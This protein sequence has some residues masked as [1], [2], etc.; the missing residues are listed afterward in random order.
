[1]R[2]DAL[3]E[4]TAMHGVR[5]SRTSEESKRLNYP[6]TPCIIISASGMATG[7]R[8]VH[9][10]A[11]LLPHEKNTVVLTGYQAAGTRGRAL[12]QGARE[13]KVTGQYVRVR[14]EVV[15]DNTFSVHADREE[16]LSWLGELPETPRT[17][18]VVHGEPEASSALAAQVRKQLDCAVVVP[19]MGERVMVS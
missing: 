18:Y 12:E 1:M 13:V 10:L 3:L 15:A 6:G 5:E 7:G 16:L 14:A 9:H 8:V 17:V 19:R 2:P 11:S 4:L